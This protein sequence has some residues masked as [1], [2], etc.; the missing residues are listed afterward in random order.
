MYFC[1]TYIPP[2]KSKLYSDVTLLENFEF[3]DCISD[4]IRYYSYIGDVYLCGDF[5][6]RTGCLSDTV[7]DMGLDRHVDLPEPDEE[8]ISIP[9][10]RSFDL[11][12][13]GFGQ[14]L[15]AYV[16]NMI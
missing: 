6:S 4:D 12:V 11:S 7:E 16:K 9:V 1:L 10:R 13:N 3:F 8:L 2:E 5:N 14:N 15:L